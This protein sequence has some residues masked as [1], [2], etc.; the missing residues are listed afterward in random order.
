MTDSNVSSARILMKAGGEVCK[1]TG[2]ALSTTSTLYAVKYLTNFGTNMIEY[3]PHLLTGQDAATTLVV[4]MPNLRAVG[5]TVGILT[6][7][8]I[9][10]KVGTWISD[11]VTITRFEKFLYSSHEDTV[12]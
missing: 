10:R 11:D 2:L 9:V 4:N 12:Q 7:G 3:L 6:G 8:V 1:L 5:A